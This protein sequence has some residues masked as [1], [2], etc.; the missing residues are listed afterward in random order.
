MSETKLLANVAA[1]VADGN[2]ASVGIKAK[3]GVFYLDVTAASGTSPT[4]DVTIQEYDDK[5]GQWY[6]VLS[7]TQAAAV[8][9]ERKVLP[10]TDV[11]ASGAYRASYVIGGTTPSFDFKVGFAD[12]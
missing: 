6:D 2:A 3:S 10:A 8:T 5:T 9:K 4:L 7:F 1:A 12:A 11:L